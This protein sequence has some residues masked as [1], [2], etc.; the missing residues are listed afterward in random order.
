M[1]VSNLNNNRSRSKAWMRETVWS[2]HLI[3]T[4]SYAITRPRYGVKE[5]QIRFKRP[6]IC[7]GQWYRP[8][9]PPKDLCMENLGGKFN[10][11]I[12]DHWSSL[13]GLELRDNDNKKFRAN[14][15]LT[16]VQVNY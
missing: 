15:K 14:D 13:S 8:Q 16:R 7:M 5:I 2:W 10:T 9:G 6:T 3:H 12:I 4:D 1:L 11:N